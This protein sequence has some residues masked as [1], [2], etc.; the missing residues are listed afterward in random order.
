MAVWKDCGETQDVSKLDTIELIGRVRTLLARKSNQYPDTYK[1]IVVLYQLGQIANRVDGTAYGVARAV[2]M[3][4]EAFMENLESPEREP[5][6][7]GEQDRDVKDVLAAAPNC[8]GGAEI[9]NRVRAWDAERASVFLS[10]ARAVAQFKQLPPDIDRLP[11][12]LPDARCASPTDPLV[13]AVQALEKDSHTF[14][15]DMLIASMGQAAVLPAMLVAILIDYARTQDDAALVQSLRDFALQLLARVIAAAETGSDVSCNSTGG[16]LA[17]HAMPNGAAFA[18]QVTDADPDSAGAFLEARYS[19]ESARGTC[20]FQAVSSLLVGKTPVLATA[21]H[22]C[23]VLDGSL[24]GTVFAQHLK[25]LA[26]GVGQWDESMSTS[27]VSGE[28]TLHFAVGVTAQDGYEMLA[29]LL[30]SLSASTGVSSAELQALTNAAKSLTLGLSAQGRA[31]LLRGAS[32]VLRPSLQWFLDKH[33]EPIARCTADADTGLRC[34]LRVLVEA[35]YDPVMTYVSA[36]GGS[37][38][39]AK[40]LS[41]VLLTQLDALDPL[42]RTP[43]LFNIGPGSTVLTRFGS[44]TPTA[45]LTLLDKYGLAARWGNR[46]QWEWGIF[47]GGF[48]DAIIRKSVGATDAAPY[49]LFGLTLGDRQFSPTFPFGVEAHVA[50]A[51]PFDVAHFGDR[52]AAAAGVNLIV[53]IDV[54]FSQ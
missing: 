33:I 24:T 29:N 42:G 12:Q 19:P 44:D 46:R 40:Q 16:K 54:V 32:D 10:I 9:A 11:E 45:H 23:K 15:I 41:G 21:P 25:I 18:L 4:H 48:I 35:A 50:L 53:P 26:P 37:E 7:F 2:A 49:W 51:N 14:R 22:L 36:P 1:Q 13:L 43:L 28:G 47:V 31:A 5:R 30:P 6:L 34:G 20:L 39:S 38:A 52:V 17:C 8:L 3:A 27:V